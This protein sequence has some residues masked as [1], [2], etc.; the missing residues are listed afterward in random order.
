MAE[1][2]PT[3]KVVNKYSVGIF[4]G[5]LLLVG[6]LY[7]VNIF[8]DKIEVS[9]PSAECGTA[10]LRVTKDDFTLKCGN[11]IAFQ[12]DTVIDYWRTYGQNSAGEEAWWERNSRF[13][14]R[15][16]KDIKLDLIEYEN[17]FD[18]VRTTRYRKGR[19][20]IEDGTLKE[21][22]TF[23]KDKVKITY[24]YKVKNKAE[25]KITMRIKKQYKAALDAFDPN[26]Y[27]GF[28]SG[29][30]LYY[31]GSG[32]L[33]IDPT[34]T[35]V[36]PANNSAAYNETDTA[37]FVCQMVNDS[38]SD[39]ANISLWW[40]AEGT[41]EQA[42]TEELS[43]TTDVNTTFSLVIP[44]QDDSGTFVWNCY[45]CNSSGTCDW[46]ANNTMNPVYAPNAVNLTGPGDANLED[47]NLLDGVSEIDTM[48]RIYPTL[49]NLSSNTTLYINW[50][51]PTH[52]DGD[53]MTF[54]LSYYGTTTTTRKYDHF[55]YSTSNGSVLADWNYSALAVD[56][57]YITIKA[58]SEDNSE[59]CSEDTYSIPIEIFDFTPSITTGES[60]IRY[61]TQPTVTQASALGQTDSKGIIQIDWDGYGA[62]TGTINLTLTVTDIDTCTTFYEHTSNNVSAV[63]TLTNATRVLVEQDARSDPEY[64]WLWLTKSSCGTTT[65]DTEY[66]FEV[67]E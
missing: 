17:S 27:T 61:S 37:P 21:I 26:G 50:T 55:R 43:G 13:V 62:P 6:G 20:N 8:D 23:S 49:L 36:S 11:R 65:I 58:C 10:L 57:Y 16:K 14:G 9:L 41:W 12:A 33:F 28:M 24:D 59:L 47:L 15:N 42:A 48:G 56:D 44:H 40:N 51:H 66:S 2:K 67:L 18:I 4:L 3:R 63:T 1:E 29:D 25:H 34:V 52:P 46:D 30:M 60:E 19:Q 45:G 5:I 53:N 7:T 22:Y 31:K 64:I 54:N 32:D 35:L 38:D 39:F